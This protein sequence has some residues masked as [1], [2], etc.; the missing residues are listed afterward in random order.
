MLRSVGCIENGGGT[1]TEY[2]LYRLHLVS[3]A[4][5]TRLLCSGKAS[6][7]RSSGDAIRTMP[8]SN[9]ASRLGKSIVAQQGHRNN[10]VKMCGF[11]KQRAEF[12]FIRKIL[13][14]KT[15]SESPAF[16]HLPTL[17]ELRHP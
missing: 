3:R 12:D 13:G 16:C 8:K 11:G 10:D 17:H 9:R 7:K 1:I 4:V 15:G 6:R 14:H 2:S 5:V